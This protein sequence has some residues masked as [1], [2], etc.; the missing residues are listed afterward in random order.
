MVTMYKFYEGHLYRSPSD[1]GLAYIENEE[2]E[3]NQAKAEF[4]RARDP[5]SLSLCGKKFLGDLG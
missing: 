1:N 5:I 2:A 3:Y 4:L